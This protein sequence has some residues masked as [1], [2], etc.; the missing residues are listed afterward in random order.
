[1]KSLIVI[2]IIIAVVIFSG[3]KRKV[4]GVS[5]EILSFIMII[6]VDVAGYLSFLLV[7]RTGFPEILEA[8]QARDG[9]FLATNGAL[10]VCILALTLPGK[11]K[12]WWGAVGIVILFFLVFNVI[13]QELKKSYYDN[14]PIPPTQV[15]QPNPEDKDSNPQQHSS[16]KT[17]KL[18][19]FTDDKR[20]ITV[21]LKPGWKSYPKGG[22]IT[23][24]T[25][26]G[27]ILEDIPGVDSYFGYQPEGTYIISATSDETTGVELY[28]YWK[29]H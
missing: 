12:R 2:L 28:N 14:M 29:Q 8:W 19:N 18:F 20:S 5:G 7:L 21:Y 25:P 3:K 9:F 6:L 23:I 26:S 11:N 22:P 1:M 27:D 24:Q 16:G 17:S 10:I 13:K 4:P 15:A